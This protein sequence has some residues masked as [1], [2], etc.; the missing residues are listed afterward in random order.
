MDKN[1]N[2]THKKS[3]L[4]IISIIALLILNLACTVFLAARIFAPAQASIT[5]SDAPF[6][7]VSK[8]SKFTLY[9]GTIDRDAHSQIIPTSEAIEIVNRI[10]A[11]HV[12]GYTVIDAEGGWIDEDG[13]FLQENTLIYIFLDT[14]KEH[15]IPFMEE[16]CAAL[17]QN[18]ILVESN[19]IT[20]TFLRGSLYERT[21]Y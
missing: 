20:G 13:A 15:L 18:S 7:A 12:K 1:L 14:S 21:I 9:I 6:S 5:D 11:K 10:C 2:Q 16:A 17:N 19:G 3:N 8:G 4:K